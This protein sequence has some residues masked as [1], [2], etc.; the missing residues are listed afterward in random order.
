MKLVHVPFILVVGI[1][2]M[3]FRACGEEERAAHVGGEGPYFSLI[4]LSETTEPSS[5]GCFKV[6]SKFTGVSG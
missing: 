6:N 5:F 2:V 1:E 4:S 3:S